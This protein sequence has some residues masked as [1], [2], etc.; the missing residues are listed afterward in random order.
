[1][2]GFPRQFEY[3]VSDGGLRVE[4]CLSRSQSL[5]MPEFID[6][7]AVTA[8]AP[9]AF[10]GNAD[11]C[12]VVC[13][14]QVTEI[15]SRAFA[16]CP[17]LERIVFPPKLD[18]YDNSWV[19]G[20]ARLEE[21]T[22]PGAVIDLDL[23]APAPSGVKRVCI[24][25]MTRT[26][27][28]ARAW[29]VRLEQVDVHPGNRWLS[30]DGACIYSADGIELV[31]HATKVPKVVVAQG[32]RRVA[33]RAFELE[34]HLEHV[35]LPEGVC[36][37][38][39]RAFA[40][41]ALRSFESPQS[42]QT[43]CRE[44][45]ADCQLLEEVRLADGLR[46]IGGRAFAGCSACSN[47]DIPASVAFVGRKAFEGTDLQPCGER[48]TLSVSSRNPALFIDDQESSASAATTASW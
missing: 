2:E 19:A 15:G 45:F 11:I 33:E 23:V 28:I 39:E 27:Q 26:V 17:S 34:K 13:S 40:E 7:M 21:I 44:A 6:G 1:M 22:L 14:P 31:V 43:I 4:R 36:E 30:S 46:E 25:E 32:C 9:Y 47:V 29:K 42:L 16:N 8:I 24:G 20:C 18:R 5:V 48:P 3:V 12:D 37:I 10:E 38:G 41:S 35:D